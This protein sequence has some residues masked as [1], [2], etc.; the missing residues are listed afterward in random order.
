V[1]ERL[2]CVGCSTELI[3]VRAPAGEVDI[4][5]G[6]EPLA[7]HGAE[8]GTQDAATDGGTLLGKRYADEDSGLELLCTKAG[9]GSLAVAGEPLRIRDPKSLPS[10]D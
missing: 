3:V 9:A 8:P 4:T 10:S 7:A 2:S 5:C 1:G 6:G